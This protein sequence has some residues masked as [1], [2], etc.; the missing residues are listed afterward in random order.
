MKELNEDEKKLLQTLEAFYPFLLE[1]E[2]LRDTQKAFF[3]TKQRKHLIAARKKEE[4]IDAK[5]KD[6]KKRIAA[7]IESMDGFYPPF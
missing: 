6:W 4:A 7:K 3:E 1:I 2:N 5:V